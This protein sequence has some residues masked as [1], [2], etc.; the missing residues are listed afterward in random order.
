MALSLFGDRAR[1]LAIIEEKERP[2]LND[3]TA[4]ISRE[5]LLYADE[6]IRDL[7]VEKQGA[8]AA[9]SLRHLLWLIR[10]E[11]EHIASWTIR[12]MVEGGCN[13]KWRHPIHAEP[14]GL[15]PWKRDARK[16]RS[17]KW[18]KRHLRHGQMS[19]GRWG[20]ERLRILAN[21]VI[22]RLQSCPG[23]TAEHI[24]NPLAN[25]AFEASVKITFARQEAYRQKQWN[26]VQAMEQIGFTID[27]A[28]RKI[29]RSEIK[30]RR[31]KHHKLLRRQATIASAVLGLSAVSA[32]ARGEPVRIEGR[33]INFEVAKAVSA[34]KV[35]HGALKIAVHAKEGTK[36]ATLCLYF[37]DT[38]ALDQ[39]VAMKLHTD[40]G[41]E[42]ELLATANLIRLE[43]AG[44][45]HATLQRRS[46]GRVEA[47]LRRAEEN[48]EA[49][50]GDVAE[51]RAIPDIL[52]GGWSWTEARAER[53]K[54][55]WKETKNIWLETLSV[56]VLGRYARWIKPQKIE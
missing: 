37:E 5:L 36:L 22:R 43:E 2:S 26:Q 11:A 17:R 42:D 39:V 10:E 44:E 30:K 29:K 18:I 14:D 31:R 33:E 23:I 4:A 48:L 1:I 35:G 12:D 40:A 49:M 34:A 20:W 3:N 19:S 13:E 56:Q 24:N 41:L 47:Q 50:Q 53:D 6:L 45:G 21:H 46:L 16:L 32:F 15:T 54:A 9:Y 51:S 28:I 25:K 7:P 8:L 55:Y 52:H 27:E 38:P